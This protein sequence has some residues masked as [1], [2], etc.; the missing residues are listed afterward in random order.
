MS[1]E[2]NNIGAL[3]YYKDYQCRLPYWL[4][5]SVDETERYFEENK[6]RAIKLPKK[7][8]VIAIWEYIIRKYPN[9]YEDIKQKLISTC[10]RVQSK[11]EGQKNVFSLDN[12]EYTPPTRILLPKI[13]MDEVSEIAS[14]NYKVMTKPK[15]WILCIIICNKAKELSEEKGITI[16][17][18]LREQIEYYTKRQHRVITQIQ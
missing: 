5:N 6:I 3:T 13:L 18:M 15:S 8:Y 2:K 16:N 17:Y 7:T 1:T 11:I 14:K 9:E 10:V 4:Q 12:K